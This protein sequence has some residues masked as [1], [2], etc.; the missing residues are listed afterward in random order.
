MHMGTDRMDLEGCMPE[1]SDWKTGMLSIHDCHD[2][3]FL[4]QKKAS[5]LIILVEAFQYICDG[6]LNQCNAENTR[7]TEAE[8]MEANV[9]AE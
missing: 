8:I 9:G 5:A 3:V 1:W 4:P 7:S 2:Y 6:R